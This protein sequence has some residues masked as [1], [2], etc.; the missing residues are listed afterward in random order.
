MPR[1]RGEKYSGPVLIVLVLW[2]TLYTINHTARL[3]SV[4]AADLCP[5]FSDG[6]HF[7]LMRPNI[8]ISDMG[9]KKKPILSQKVG[10]PKGMI[11]LK[12][13]GCKDITKCPVPGC[14]KT[15]RNDKIIEHQMELVMFNDDD[16]AASEENP[17]FKDLSNAGKNHTLYFRSV[18]ATK[19]NLP[20]NIFIRSSKKEEGKVAQGRQRKIDGF[21]TKSGS[22][23]SGAIEVDSDP[24]DPGSIETTEDE[25]S[26]EGFENITVTEA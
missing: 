14:E 9:K 5:P 4:S 24:D 11:K 2:C 22:R 18:G 15:A 23:L 25:N 21:F 8:K 20:S 1:V 12:L 3:S 6:K 26:R 13:Y 17:R 16:Q 7:I 10:R 19:L